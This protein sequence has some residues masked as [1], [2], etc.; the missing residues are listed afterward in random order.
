VPLKSVT[1][2]KALRDS[3][4]RKAVRCIEG[5]DAV[6]RSETWRGPPKK[7]LSDEMPL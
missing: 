3:I 1:P 5:F 7:P 6:N 2:S 4:K